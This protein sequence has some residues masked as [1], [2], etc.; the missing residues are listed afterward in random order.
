MGEIWNPDVVEAT[1]WEHLCK[2][3]DTSM[4]SVEPIS[5]Q[6]VSLAMR[7]RGSLVREPAAAVGYYFARLLM[8][9]WLCA[10]LLT[11]VSGWA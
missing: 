9:L 6:L 4:V 10:G 8:W 2:V 5:S 1:V 3:V 7:D 11:F